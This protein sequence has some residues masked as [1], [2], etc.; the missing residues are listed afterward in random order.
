MTSLKSIL[1]TATGAVFFIGAAAS[2]SPQAWSE[3]EK[4]VV[5]ACFAATGFAKPE[6]ESQVIAL[7]DSIGH[8]ALIV[9][10]DYTQPHMKGQDGKM[11]CLFNKTTRKATVAEIQDDD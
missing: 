6:V 3:H 5:T 9:E 4:E 10:G 2:S 11:L 8:D 7:D 1:A